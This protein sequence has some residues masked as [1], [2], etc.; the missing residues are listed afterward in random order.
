[1]GQGQTRPHSSRTY[2]VGSIGP[3]RKKVKYHTRQYRARL[4]NVQFVPG[5]G[6]TT[7]WNKPEVRSRGRLGTWIDLSKMRSRKFAQAPQLYKSLSGLTGENLMLYEKRARP[8]LK[9]ASTIGT[10]FGMRK[11]ALADWAKLY[12]G[13]DIKGV[14]SRIR[15]HGYL[16]RGPGHNRALRWLYGSRGRRYPI[17]RPQYAY[18]GGAEIQAN[19]IARRKKAGGKWWTKPLGGGA[20]P[21]KKAKKPKK[22]MSLLPKLV[23]TKPKKKKAAAKKVVI[24]HKG[25]NVVVVPKLNLPSG[26]ASP[27]SKAKI[28]ANVPKLNLPS[29]VVPIKKEPKSPSMTVLSSSPPVRPPRLATHDEILS[30]SPSA[31]LAYD[32]RVQ[33]WMAENRNKAYETP[34]WYRVKDNADFARRVLNH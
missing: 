23:A 11:Q 1:M 27:W 22:V 28:S 7:F 26:R 20:A 15:K 31:L 2:R 25:A 30:M 18:A 8:T 13:G 3:G 9:Q 21:K 24:A 6:S 4:L 34:L 33:N 19:A 16:G 29:P 32:S 5:K 10:D 17:V 14:R 12:A